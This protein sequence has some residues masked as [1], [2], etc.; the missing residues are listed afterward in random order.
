MRHYNHTFIFGVKHSFTLKSIFIKNSF[1][2]HF[3]GNV[4]RFVGHGFGGDC[5]RLEQG[6]ARQKAVCR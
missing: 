6:T 3:V 5:L 2:G 1:V 4:G